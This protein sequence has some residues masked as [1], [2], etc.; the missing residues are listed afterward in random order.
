VHRGVAAIA[1]AITAALT[2]AC[3]STAPAS[4]QPW[5]PSHPDPQGIH[6]AAAQG[7]CTITVRYP[8]EAPGEIDAEGGVYIQRDRTAPQSASGTPMATSGDWKLNRKD[9]HTL[10]LTTPDATFVYQDGA[11]CGSNSAAPT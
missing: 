7:L 11:N 6:F 2:A 4:E 1:V 3:G 10:L 5:A 8:A 9:A